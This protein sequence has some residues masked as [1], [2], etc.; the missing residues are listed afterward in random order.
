MVKLY[1][2]GRLFLNEKQLFSYKK[3]KKCIKC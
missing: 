2:W 3:L 1:K